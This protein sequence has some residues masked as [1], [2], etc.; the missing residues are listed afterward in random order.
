MEKILNQTRFQ[1]G[2]GLDDKIFEGRKIKQKKSVFC[3]NEGQSIG[4]IL[5]NIIIF[6]FQIFKSN[7]LYE[8]I[9]EI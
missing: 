7:F 3:I 8:G 1:N 9:F 6:C 2:S 4:K 5:S